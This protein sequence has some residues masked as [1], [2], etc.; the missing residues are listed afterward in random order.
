LTLVANRNSK[1][2]KFTW[3]TY[4]EQ[5]S[6]HGVGWKVYTAPTGG[7][8]L[9][10]VLPYFKRY[11]TNPDLHRRG[12]ESTYP[13]DFLA[14]IQK[15]HLPHVSWVL[16]TVNL[17]EHPPFAPDHGEDATAHVLKALTDRPKLWAKT[18]LIVTYDE[19]GGFFDHVAP[20]VAPRGT[21]GEYLTVQNLPP[22]ADG[23]R[24]PI[25]LGF[26]VPT[27]VV[28]PFSRGGFVCSERFDH[29]SVLRLLEERFGV[30][31]PNLT[32]WRRSV[33]GDLTSAFNFKKPNRS[34][35]HLPQTSSTASCGGQVAP[36][37]TLPNKQPKQE[38][39]TPR[40]PSGPC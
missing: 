6:A 7:G 16:P 8:A 39:G 5:L 26:R 29:T 30:E 34:I 38:K 32:H 37:P 23:I 24:G 14:D 20:K 17:T 22:E 12:I 1:A 18:A 28:S 21:H 10:N 4:P 31:V 19:N 13:N 33:T 3:K 40:R 15:G 11:Q 2:G 35:P 9:Q 27:L 25:G 36:Q